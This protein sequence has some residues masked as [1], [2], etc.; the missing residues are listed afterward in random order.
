MK[1]LGISVQR[2]K[3]NIPLF[4][5]LIAAGFPSPAQDYVEQTLDLNELCI[6]HPAAT[7]FVR[8]QG[9]SMI[10]AGIFNGDILVV[11]RSLNPEH[12]DTVVASV[13]G[14]FTVKQLQLRPTIQLIPR[15]AMFSAIPISDESELSLFGV[16]TS[17]VKKLK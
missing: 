9:D 13:N 15:N 17:V 10:E 4:S 2:E 14:E 6:R 5:S 7:Y 8:V 12:G 16:V 1:V 3:Y 11:D